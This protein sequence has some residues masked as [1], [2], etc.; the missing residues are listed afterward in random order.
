MTCSKNNQTG[1]LNIL[2]YNLCL[3]LRLHVTSVLFTLTCRFKNWRLVKI[4][5]PKRS[6]FKNKVFFFKVGLL[7]F[8]HFDKRCF[9][10]RWIKVTFKRGMLKSD[11]SRC[12]CCII[13][14]I[15]LCREVWSVDIWIS[16]IS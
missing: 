6:V 14:S 9:S 7:Y 3:L 16:D 1:V 11:V 5:S 2:H 8:Q 10:L 15:N 13:D 12:I 4:S